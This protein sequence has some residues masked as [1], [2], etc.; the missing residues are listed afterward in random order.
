MVDAAGMISKRSAAQDDG[1][2]SAPL[3]SAD[4]CGRGCWSCRRCGRAALSRVCD[5]SQRV[6][7]PVPPGSA[8]RWQAALGAELGSGRAAWRRN[9]TGWTVAAPEHKRSAG[10]G[11]VMTGGSCGWARRPVRVGPNVSGAPASANN[12]MPLPVTEKTSEL[13]ECF[14]GNLAALW[15]RWRQPTA[16][17]EFAKHVVA[18][19]GLAGVMKA[20]DGRMLARRRPQSPATWAKAGAG[21]PGCRASSKRTTGPCDATKAPSGVYAGSRRISSVGATAPEG[22]EA[23]SAAWSRV[24]YWS[25]RAHGTATR[26]QAERR[27]R[28]MS[29]P[30]RERCA[31]ASLF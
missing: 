5:H 25:Q 26:E 4:D 10:P 3:A 19:T 18:N 21:R 22:T 1:A 12:A 28:S 29:D 11:R 13:A 15:R 14:R 9:G 30:E 24:Q 2:R 31:A 23:G 7:R 8:T 6:K 27:M 16:R 17:R 20:Q